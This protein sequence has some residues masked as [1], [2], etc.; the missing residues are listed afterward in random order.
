MDWNL[1]RPRRS[2]SDV[3]FWNADDTTH[4]TWQCGGSALLADLVEAFVRDLRGRG[5][6]KFSIRQTD[7]ADACVRG[8]RRLVPIGLHCTAPGAVQ[9]C[10]GYTISRAGTS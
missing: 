3:S 2:H 7:H 1:A 5:A 4:T 8:R 9:A 10:V 6:P